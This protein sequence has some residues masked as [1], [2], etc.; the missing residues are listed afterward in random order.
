MPIATHLLPH[1]FVICNNNN[2]IDSGK[3]FNGM[4]EGAQLFDQDLDEW[5]MS[6]AVSVGLLFSLSFCLYPFRF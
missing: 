6:N 2:N 4:F 3:K 5:D 1:C